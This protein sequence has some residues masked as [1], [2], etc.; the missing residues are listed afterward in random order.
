MEQY[1]IIKYS[2]IDLYVKIWKIINTPKSK[3][4]SKM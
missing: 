3:G 2:G 4:K 1:A